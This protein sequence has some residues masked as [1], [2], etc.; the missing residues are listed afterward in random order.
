MRPCA[1]LRAW[2]GG[3]LWLAAA[4]CGQSLPEG[5][6][7]AQSHSG[8][9]SVS[10]RP[11]PSILPETLAH[12]VAT[13]WVRLQPTLLAMTCERIKDALLLR[14]NA[15]DQWQGKV[16]IRL[17]PVRRVDDPVRVTQTHF[18]DGWV[19]VVEMPDAIAPD[20]LLRT[21]VQLL[22]VEWANR[23]TST[24]ADV[25]L[26]LPEGLAQNLLSDSALDLFLLPPVTKQNNLLMRET[27][28][29]KRRGAPLAAARAYFAS[30]EPLDFEDLCWP[31]PLDA[32]GVDAT[33]YRYSA[34]FL[35]TELLRLRGGGQSLAAMLDG[36]GRYRN[37]QTAFLRAFAP[38]FS[39]TLD[40]DKWWT[41]QIAHFLQRGDS[42]T[43]RP[44]E[45]LRQLNAVLTVTFASSPTNPA[46]ARVQVSLT[47]FLKEAPP[48][49]Q[50][51]VL[52][53]RVR[54][55]EALAGRVS[56]SLAPLTRD[57]L[58]LLQAHARE[59]DRGLRGTPTQR[60][61][62]Y[63]FNQATR[64]VVARLEAL[65]AQR[66]RYGSNAAPSLPTD[67]T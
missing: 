12:S 37:W 23:N 64:K 14:L 16:N 43:W 40:V 6:T 56:P 26:W 28:V 8:Q 31:P 24:L 18:K 7:T 5:G 61:N 47:A 57:Y 44:S 10:G 32:P 30:H 35:V 9:F 60:L 52:Q 33:G 54:Q 29:R 36:L 48:Q 27:S 4:A 21:I 58:K 62:R 1:L 15:R 67:K 17:R 51:E 39:R 50:E 2:L 25:P 13:N 42:L 65:D 46:A 38:H 55:L 3:L 59:L 63:A 34:E 49:Q 66:A 53:P 41:L 11:A 45:S 20:R 19:Y 22:V